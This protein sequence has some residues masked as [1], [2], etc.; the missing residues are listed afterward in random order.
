[1]AAA[2]AQGK[3]HVAHAATMD[4]DWGTDTV[5][6]ALLEGASADA[7]VASWQPSLR[8]FDALRRKYLLY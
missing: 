1:M 2:R 3:L 5:R 7:I 4:R 6:R 8:A